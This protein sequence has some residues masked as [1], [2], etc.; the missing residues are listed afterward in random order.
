MGTRLRGR[1][2]LLGLAVALAAACRSPET[3]SGEP[4][5]DLL[6]VNGTLV[7][8]TGAAPRR[9]DVG[10]RGGAIAAVGELAGRGARATVGA[11][12]HQRFG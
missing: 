6:I 11:T 10:V 7:D 3:S 1:W 5:F 12:D 4:E 8:G 2:L 9:A